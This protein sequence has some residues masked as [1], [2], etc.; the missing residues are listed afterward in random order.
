M[1]PKRTKRLTFVLIIV[2]GMAIA[3]G[4]ALY[5]LNQNINLFYSP[6]QVVT[7]QAPK[8]HMFRIGGI[9]K[10]GTIHQI[11]HSLDVSFDVTDKVNQVEVK[12]KGILP[13]LFR[14]GQGIVVD[15]QLNHHGVFIAS[16]VLAKHDA[17]YM[18]PEVRA[19][20]KEAKHY[21]HIKSVGKIQ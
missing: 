3:V 20:L 6:S 2:I 8:H 14:A 15:G 19:A 11:P 12:Y 7:G 18:P 10:P 17:T 1:N 21:K 4:L 16:Q 9:V 13:D 5:A